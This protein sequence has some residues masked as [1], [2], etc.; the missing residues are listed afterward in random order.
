MKR[1]TDPSYSRRG[2]HHQALAD[3]EVP[4]PKLFRSPAK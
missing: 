2:I 1:A 4:L 3:L